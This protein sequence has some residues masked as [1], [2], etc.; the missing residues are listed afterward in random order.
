MHIG[1]QD[2]VTSTGHIT[3]PTGRVLTTESKH[4]TE[5]H[6]I[7][8]ILS[9]LHSVSEVRF[10]KEEKSKDRGRGCG[11]AVGKTTLDRS[12]TSVDLRQQWNQL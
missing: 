8:K 2:S 9:K 4:L 11:K 7:C 6:L 3:V 12:D 5:I 10:P 1:W